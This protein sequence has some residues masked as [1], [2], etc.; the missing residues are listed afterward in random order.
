MG[1]FPV[2]LLLSM[3]TNNFLMAN[4][5]SKFPQNHEISSYKYD[6]QHGGV[7]GISQP[8]TTVMCFVKHK[9]CDMFIM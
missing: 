2:R 6:L 8:G 9:S 4:V 3:G 7:G 1:V 5:K